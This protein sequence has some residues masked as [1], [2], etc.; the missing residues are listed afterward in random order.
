MIAP[1]FRASDP[2]AKF[3]ENVSKYIKF[4]YGMCV[5]CVSLKLGVSGYECFL[6]NF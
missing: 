2:Q 4:N 1:D 6:N 3:A 5:V